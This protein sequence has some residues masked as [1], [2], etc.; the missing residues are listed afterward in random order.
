M[1]K[2]MSYVGTWLVITVLIG[3][4]FVPNVIAQ[5]ATPDNTTETT[6]PVATDPPTEIPVVP[7]EVP[8]VPTEIPVIPTEIPVVP[9]QVPVIPTD[10]PSVVTE[11]PAIP[12]GVPTTPASTTAPLQRN[13]L[14]PQSQPAKPTTPTPPP[15]TP[16]TT[17]IVARCPGSGTLT[18]ENPV[19]GAT[20]TLALTYH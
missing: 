7:T 13:S 18:V 9:T 16:T 4:L 14:A 2:Y 5:Q 19:A 3:L 12:T 15:A 1:K 8:V 10:V 6:Q 11:I 20:I 17:S